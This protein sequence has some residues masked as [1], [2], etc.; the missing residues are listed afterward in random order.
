MINLLTRLVLLGKYRDTQCGLKAF[1]S[2][3]YVDPKAARIIAGVAQ[4]LTRRGT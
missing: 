4:T 1:R 3:D 2:D